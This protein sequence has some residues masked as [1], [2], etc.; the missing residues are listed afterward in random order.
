MLLEAISKPQIA[1]EGK[2]RGAAYTG[3]CEHFAEALNPASGRDHR[4]LDG[5]L[6]WLLEIKPK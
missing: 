1:A 4:A 2:A 6:K 3:V 5:V